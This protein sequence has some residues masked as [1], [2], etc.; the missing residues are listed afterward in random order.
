MAEDVGK[1]Q[2][3]KEQAEDMRAVE[4][5]RFSETRK[6]KD[7]SDEGSTGM[8]KKRRRRSEVLDWLKGKVEYEKK[9]RESEAKKHQEV[10]E[11]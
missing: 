1:R 7:N 11:Y 6:R 4:L 3:E 2:A 8:S 10:L 5:E 9:E